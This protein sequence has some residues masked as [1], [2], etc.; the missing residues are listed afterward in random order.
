MHGLI[1]FQAYSALSVFTPPNLTILIVLGKTGELFSGRSVWKICLRSPRKQRDSSWSLSPMTITR[2]T[3]KGSPW[4][5][6]PDGWAVGEA[7]PTSLSGPA[8]GSAA[9]LRTGVRHRP[10]DLCVVFG[11]GCLSDSEALNDNP[12]ARKLFDVAKF[13]EQSQG[14]NG[15]ASNLRTASRRCA[16]SC[17][18]S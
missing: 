11:G 17:E 5:R 10:V 13:A 15:C 9:W 4:R 18:S 1:G 3:P 8:R 7:A 12:L 14:A 6:W 2:S 16:T